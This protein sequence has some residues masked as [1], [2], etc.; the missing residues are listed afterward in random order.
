M[1]LTI[2][3]THRPATDLGYLLHKNPGRFQSYD[4]SF[5]K[6]HVFY[7]EA[8]DDRC[9]A[10]L[11][12]DVDPVGIVRG[13]GSSEGLLSQY[14]NDRPYV[15][16]SFL[17]V[18]ISQVYGSALQGRCKDRPDLAAAPIPL[19]ARIDVVPVRGGETFLRAV[20]EPLGYAV[21]CERHPLDERFPEWGESPYFSVTVA[22]ETTLSELLTHLYVLV[23][24]FDNQK[25]YFVGDD[26][27]EK[28]LAKGG[29]WLGRHPE[30]EEIARR[31]LKFRPSLFRQALDRLVAEEQPLETE[32]DDRPVDKAEDALERPL[33]LNEQRIGAVMAAIRA[34]GARRVLDLGCGEGKLLGLL[35]A[36]RQ[37]GHITG[38][39]VSARSLEIA[40]RRLRLDRMGDRQ[41]ERIRLL[42]GSLVYRDPRLEEGFD[43]AAVV[44]VVEHLD[45]WRL[46]AFERILFGHVRPATVVLTTP[47]R[48]YNTRFEGL[49]EG[50][51]RHAD[52]RFE[53]TRPELEA[54]A[55]GICERHGYTVALN[56]VGD[57]DPEVGAPSQ[58]AVFSR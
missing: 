57:D 21:E 42:H 26:E 24:V 48:E 43:A 11:L 41:R 53:W 58:M 6:A 23:P 5:G 50:R 9:T 12:L 52:H 56:G 27:M 20:F 14:V 31:Y 4:L 28:L 25:H 7:P 19:E 46:V 16:S 49:A 17:S 44:E 15:A 18:A 36:E 33:S 10:C 40:A 2:T 38:V 39:D 45:P 54:W 37:F 1:L 35:L 29:G 47:N 3:T 32:G 13:K 55:G 8:G 51:L 30:R 34:G 22:K